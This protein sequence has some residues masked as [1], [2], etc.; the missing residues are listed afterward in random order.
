MSAARVRSARL[1]S[2]LDAVGNTPLLRL[3]KVA[4]EA[5]SVEVWLKL[6]FHNPGG[7]VKD[8]AALRMMLTALADGRLGA[9]QTLLDSTSG[10]TGVAY[11]LFGAAL[12]V[13][14][15]LCDALEREPATQGHRARLRHPRRAERPHGGLGRRHPPRARARR[16]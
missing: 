9:G 1:S 13:P 5:P 11:S 3:R 4:R 10:N 2:V 16:S 7:S 15:T 12:G 8:R 14:V 6:E